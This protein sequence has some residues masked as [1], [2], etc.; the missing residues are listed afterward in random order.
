MFRF[1][2]YTL[3][4]VKQVSALVTLSRAEIWR[5]TRERRFPPPIRLGP[6]RVAWLYKD[7][8]SWISDMAEFGEWMPGCHEDGAGDGAHTTSSTESARD[9]SRKPQAEAPILPAKDR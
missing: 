9:I 5:R 8:R 7:V 6:A 3:L 2:P 4:T 1:D